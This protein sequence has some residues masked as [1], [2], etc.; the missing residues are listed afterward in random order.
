[1][2]KTPALFVFLAVF[3]LS[4]HAENVRISF[5]ETLKPWVMNDGKGGILIDM[6]NACLKPSGHTISVRLFPYTRRLIEYNNQNVDAVTDINETIIANNRLQGHY[7]GDLYAYK[8]YFYSLSE[9]NFQLD[10]I[11]DI[12]QRSLVSWQGAKF[13]L[14]REYQ[15]MALNN[16]SYVEI[17]SQEAQVRLLAEGRTDFIQM[18]D[19]I[20][21]YYRQSL[22]DAGKVE[23]NFSVDRF[24]LLGASANG[25]MFRS[26]S[27]RDD[28]VRN[29][30]KLDSDDPLHK[31]LILERDAR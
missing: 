12:G 31:I 27:V 17:D 6:L 13:T 11:A 21:N 1:M 15:E 28:C 16:S 23:K 3:S 26:K 20:F 14:G 29:L 2:K 22:I 18:D 4:V 10:T 9:N 5:G 19:E 7:T 30:N 8:N 25:I 24:S